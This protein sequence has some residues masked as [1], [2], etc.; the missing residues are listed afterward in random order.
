[1]NRLEKLWFDRLR[2]FWKEALQYASYVARSGFLAFLFGVFIVGI[3]AYNKTLETLPISFPYAW[4]TTPVL[5]LALAISPIRT[6]IKAAD[7]VFLLPAEQHMDRY[8]RK[9]WIYSFAFQAISVII[10]CLVVW[11]LYRHC[12]GERKESLLLFLLFLLLNKFIHL[13][14]S[15]HEGRL[16]FKRHRI[17][18]QTLRWCLSFIIIYV[19]FG[20]G[21][22]L[23]SIVLLF[24]CSVILLLFR[25]APLHTIHWDYL[26]K[27]EQ[28]H[29]SA[30][31]LFFSW[32]V[33]VP[34]RVTQTKHRSLLSK[35]TRLY[36]F[37]PSNTYL[38]LYTK[39]LLRSEIFRIM[40]R[41]TLIGI[42]LVSVIP[43]DTAGAI[44][45]VMVIY[46]SSIQISALEQ[47]HRYAF[48]LHLY[49]LQQEWQVKALSKIFF[50]LLV[51]QCCT[52]SLVL[53][54]VNTSLMLNAFCFSLCCLLGALHSFVIYPR[55]LQRALLQSQ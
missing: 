40:A 22:I 36:A 6:F 43:N 18:I 41:V 47:Q 49:P 38:Y 29:Q 39:T 16:V 24:A 52:L 32:F 51:L 31:Y 7:A 34:Q 25:G 28:K 21:L 12:L 48:W 23:A 1:L 46:I 44:I 27:A 17:Q 15:W 53:L 33:D 54:L 45:Y 5:L 2:G 50:T 30:H 3:Y 4:I 19:L 13:L 20:Y 11:P 42:L 8:F 37:K 9:S 14:S 10:A 26:I 35:W 55:K